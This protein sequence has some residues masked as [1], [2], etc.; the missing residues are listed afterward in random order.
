[1]EGCHNEESELM[2]EWESLMAVLLSLSL[3]QWRY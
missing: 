1:M 3:S 2:Q